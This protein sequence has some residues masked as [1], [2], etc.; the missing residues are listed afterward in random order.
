MTVTRAGRTMW[1]S[2]RKP[3]GSGIEG[4]H[5]TSHPPA[6]RGLLGRVSVRGCLGCSD[7]GIMEAAGDEV[8]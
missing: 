6:R 5:W 4:F 8:R 3:G 2:I 7:H 1:Q